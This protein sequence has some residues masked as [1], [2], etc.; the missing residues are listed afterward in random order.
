[1][2][3]IESYKDLEAWR[4]AVQ[5]TKAVYRLSER[6][7]TEER[8]GLISQIRRASV[9]IPSNIAE[10]W[11]RQSTQDYVRFLRMARGSIF[12]VE[13]QIV[14][15]RE[16]GFVADEQTTEADSILKDAGRVLAG[17]IRSIERKL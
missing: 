3:T 9:S 1:L 15:A 5:A 11:G 10:G 14:L 8:F 2:Q 7:P 13:T 6:F 12:E 17:L 4:L 16:L